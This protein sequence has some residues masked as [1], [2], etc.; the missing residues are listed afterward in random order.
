MRY[1]RDILRIGFT[2][3]LLAGAVAGSSAAPRKSCSISS[4]D[5]NDGL[6]SNNVKSILQDRFGFMWFG[7]KNGLNRYD[8]MNIRR[9]NCYDHELRRGNDNIS[10]L[11][12]RNDT[13]WVG[14]DRGVFTYDMRRERFSYLALRNR[15]GVG[16]EDWVESIYGDSAGNIWVLIPNQGVFR[17][18]DGVLDYYSVTD[19]KGDKSKLPQSMTLMGDAVYVG[20]SFQGLF[21][22]DASVNNFKPVGN[23]EVR[24]YLGGKILSCLAQVSGHVILLGTHTGDLSMYDSI[25]G[26]LRPLSFSLSGK[27]FLRTLLVTGD[28]IWIGT[29]NGMYVLD[30]SD[31]S[32]TVANAETLGDSG[33]SD[34][35]IYTIYPDREGNVWIGTL[36]GGVNYLQRNG[37]VFERYTKGSSASSLTGKLIRGMAYSP[38]GYVWIGHE[39]GGLD[40]LNVAS[41][42]VERDPLRLNDGAGILMVKNFGGNIYAGRVR[43]G[44]AVINRPS[45]LSETLCRNLQGTDNSVYSVL[46]D[47]K[48]NLWVG[49]E[50]GLYVRPAGSREFEEVEEIGYDWI[51]DIYETR[52]GS[53]WIASMGNGAWTFDPAGKKF[54]HHAFDENHSNGLRS[55]SVSS[56]M[57]DSKGRIW[58]STDR[59]GL[60][61]YNPEDNCFV[62][63][64]IEEGLPDNV[65]YNVVEDKLGYLWF[66]TNNGLVKFD[67]ATARVKHFS[68]QRGDLMRTFSYN[69]AVK[70]DD[71]RLYFG[72]LGGVI[73]FDPMKDEKTDSLPPLFLTHLRIGNEEIAPGEGMPLRE[74]LLFT[75]ELRIPHTGETI[76]FTVASPNYSGHEAVSYCYRL[77]PNDKEWITINDS[78]NLSFAGLPSGDY[79]LELRADN[80]SSS[81]IRPYRLSILPSWYESWWAYLIYAM[82][83]GGMAVSAWRYYRRRQE[84][85]MIKQAKVMSIRREKELYQNKIQFFTEIAHEIRTP[86][87]LIGSPLEAI[88]EIGV[89]DERVQRYLSIIRMNTN[90]LLDLTNHL[91]DFQKIDAEQHALSFENVDIVALVHDILSRFELTMSLKN[92]QLEVNIP[93]TA[94]VATI[95][96]EAITKIISNLFNNALK[97]SESRISIGFEAQDDVCR[98]SV[99]SDGGVIEGEHRLRIFEPFYQIESS[100]HEGGV[101]IGLPLASTLAKL[102]NGSLSLADNSPLSNTF[103][104]ELPLRQE[105]FEPEPEPSAAVAEFVM[106]EEAGESADTAGYSILFVE[107]NAEMRDFLSEQLSKSFTVE[108]AVDGVEALEILADR[109]FDIV[110]TDIMMPRMDGYELCSRIKE[111]VDRS[112][113][114]VVFLT[115]KNDL[116][117]KVKALKC[118][119]EAY[120]EKPFSI[121]YFRTQILSLLDNR[122]NERKAFLKK[123]FFSVDNM[124]LN[125]ADE[126]FMN[127][128]VKIITDNISD[129]N[130]TVEAMAEA[131]CMSRSSLLRRIKT[132]FNLSPV[133]LI[134]LIKLKRA[135]ELIQEGKYRIGD[136]C[137][138]VG[139]N[140]SSYFSKLFFKQFGVTPK[141]FEKQCQKNSQQAG[142][143][144]QQNIIPNIPEK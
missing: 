87:S 43:N 66:G 92:K 19:H 75:D 16:A 59:G 142:H 96:R 128:V 130:F 97:Y 119:G 125:K 126:E 33:L 24:R 78:R 133:E 104:L 127:R 2:V 12:E 28:E 105:G 53:I 123:P 121:K 58:L 77:L 120:I 86:L 79:T 39:D 15:E 80:G 90:R 137:Y 69:S 70:D 83:L 35:T 34:N 138:M 56:I 14:T 38:D 112:N 50:W 103:V 144:T 99:S 114:P 141:V 4:I 61:R 52:D 1:L 22:Y 94:V 73:S 46:E 62:T 40:R 88:D 108:T 45:T 5:N 111:N 131:F 68:S 74:N 107:D 41:R 136:V 98:L 31:G 109:K 13:L 117:S 3:L 89:R 135:A 81:T 71:G 29:H 57:E 118:G 132:L 85:E 60:S 106:G 67:P 37:L 122:K 32:E 30:L 95:D 110:V 49:L 115:A 48:G 10:A 63:Y 113:I 91:L 25:T 116:D 124:K 129:E 27:Q 93:D 44:V 55:N 26:E 100:G 11:F 6:S 64:S 54:I 101:G 65:V 23:P 17:V 8:G 140:S 18:R 143:S 21:K 76:S 47:R 82:I 20:T 139:I 51:S 36:F 134:R 84:R 9:Y 102:H 7:T 72:G 42:Q